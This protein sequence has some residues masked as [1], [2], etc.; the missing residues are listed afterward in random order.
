MTDAQT[1]QFDALAKALMQWLCE[2]ANPHA[3]VIVTPTTA[4]L[5]SGEHAI[6]THEFVKD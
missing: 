3:T 5:L 6:E 4:E 2:N 1:K